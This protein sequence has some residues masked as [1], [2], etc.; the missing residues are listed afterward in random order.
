MQSTKGRKISFSE[1]HTSSEIHIC[2]LN[3]KTQPGFLVFVLFLILGKLTL[4]PK[5]II[6]RMNFNTAFQKYLKI[7][8]GKNSLGILYNFKI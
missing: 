6:V 8:N 1:N 4:T 5:Q 3:N 2:I 7:L